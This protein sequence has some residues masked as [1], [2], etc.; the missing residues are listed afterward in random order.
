MEAATS[1]ELARGRWL[2][3]AVVHSAHQAAQ[4]TARPDALTPWLAVLHLAVIALATVRP[5][6][7]M[8]ALA[9]LGVVQC[10]AAF[11]RTATHL[12]LGVAVSLLLCLLDPADPADAA[13]LRR[14]AIALPLIVFAWSGLQKAIH[15]Y[16][17][18]G[19]LLAWTIVSRDDVAIVVRP[20]LD[21]PTLTHLQ[22][23]ERGVE[24]SGPFRMQGLWV[25]VS[26]LVWISELLSPLLAL[27]HRSRA[28]LWWLLLVATWAIQLVAHE[29]QFALLFSNLLLC[30]AEQRVQPVG[31]A[32]TLGALALLV[33]A[34]L[35][36]V[37]LM[38]ELTT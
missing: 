6:L 4:L 14:S 16:W 9:M 35:T 18:S 28:Q 31:R 34:R 37:G 12:F 32:L 19:E 26:N 38:P 29:W 1:T 15:G 21:A 17:F 23:L 8:A 2:G 27:W 25:M 20:L 5:R 24:G 7:A 22:S 3:A 36:G 11:P 10:A 30:A 13:A 33:T